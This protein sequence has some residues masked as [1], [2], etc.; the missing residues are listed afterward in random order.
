MEIN[1]QIFPKKGLLTNK[2]VCMQFSVS[3]WNRF[4]KQ[5]KHFVYDAHIPVHPL[6]LGEAKG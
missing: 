6:S 1:G 5:S 4:T 3:P 2:L